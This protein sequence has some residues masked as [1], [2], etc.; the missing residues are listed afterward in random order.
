MV[1]IILI[2]LVILYIIGSREQKKQQMQESMQAGPDSRNTNDNNKI[3]KKT[4]SIQ[5][6]DYQNIA[7]D[8]SINNFEQNVLPYLPNKYEQKVISNYYDAINR[9]ANFRKSNP[10]KDS[11]NN[12]IKYV[13]QSLKSFDDLIK[14]W[15][16]TDGIPPHL[17]ARDDA[18]DIFMRIYDFKSA[19]QL[20]DYF[21]KLGLAENNSLESYKDIKNRINLYEEVSNEV[22]KY[23]KNNNIT[24]HKQ[25]RKDL[26]HLDSHA[27]TWVLNRTYFIKRTKYENDKI[28]ELNP[29][30]IMD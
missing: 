11:I 25:I 6:E 15:K 17:P 3:Y 14:Y 19:H 28:L 2:I 18:P 27:L 30:F 12:Y 29:D 8:E 20:N 4:I 23:I 26:Q 13:N 21:N 7:V 22:I 9:L 10:T 1:Y 5:K 24:T 16:R